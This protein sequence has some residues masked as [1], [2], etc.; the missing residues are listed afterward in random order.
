[1]QYSAF[2]IIDIMFPC[3][4]KPTLLGCWQWVSVQISSAMQFALASSGSLFLGL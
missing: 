4:V 1:M 2:C 3:F